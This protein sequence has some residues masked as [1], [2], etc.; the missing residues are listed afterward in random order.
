MSQSFFADMNEKNK[1]KI[2]Q[3]NLLYSKL[4]GD[5]KK[6][7]FV[8]LFVSSLCFTLKDRRKAAGITQIEMAK[9]MGIK[10]SYVSKIENFEKI[11]TVETIAKYCYALNDSLG[12]VDRF[13]SRIALPDKNA[14]KTSKP[15]KRGGRDDL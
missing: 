8:D 12:S 4:S 9:A 11:P 7:Y 1:R 5:A 10:Q 6:E 15:K 3:E 14:K 13:V 2:E